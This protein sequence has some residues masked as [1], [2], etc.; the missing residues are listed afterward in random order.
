MD[1]FSHLLLGFILGQALGLDT[2]LQLIL[3][4]SSVSL[5]I[6]ALPIR[7]REAVLRTHR[8]PLHS[9]LVALLASLAIATGYTFF[10]HLPATTLLSVILICLAGLLSHLLLDVSTTGGIT[11]LWPFSRKNIAL[12]LT[13][14]I[15]PTF[16][17]TL[18]IAALSIIVLKTD[19][20]AVRIVAA[21]AVT[22]LTLTSGVRYCERNA[23]TKIIKRLGNGVATE[24]VSLPTLRPD[25]WWTIEKIHFESGHRYEIY[26]VDSFRKK[27][28]DKDTVES[29]YTHYSG[30]ADPPIDSPQKAIACSKK[31]E[32]I[33]ATVDGFVLPAVSINHSKEDDTWQVFWHDAFTYAVK[34]EQRGIL[35]HIKVDGTITTEARWPHTTPPRDSSQVKND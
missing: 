3:I 8:G 18:L 9:V 30:P 13:H 16:L 7:S 27:I 26:R 28:L 22:F 34:R 2:N 4:V 12:N 10:M 33:S 1:V 23:A 24:I 32:R 29:P 35:A 20:T 19:T 11:A 31:N 17:V 6:D 21:A 25:R 14:F 15:D 5:D